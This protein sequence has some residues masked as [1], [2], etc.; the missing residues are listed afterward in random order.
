[1]PLI[2]SGS[3]AAVSSNIR[4]MMKSG[5]PQ[6][7]AVAA[8]LSTARRYGRASGGASTF[9]NM[10]LKGSSIGL[11]KE[12]MIR[13]TV[14]GRTDKLPMKVK[15]GSYILPA[16]IPSALGQGNTMAGGEVLKNM[17]S[18]GPYGLAPM[19]GGRG[20][21]RPGLKANGGEVAEE[22]D[23]HVPI[24]A[25]GGEYIIHPTVV[26][27]VGYGGMKEGHDAL[28]RFV[29]HTRKKYIETLKK[30]PGPKK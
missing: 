29:V 26:Q 2:K 8:A 21:I 12:G 19:K 15:A 5:H 17:F 23:D 28:D 6:K 11:V 9:S 4:E 22:D 10:A 16:D 27:A 14:P 13:S 1:M 18:S 20:R 7:Q 24:I 3:K 25:A 30:L